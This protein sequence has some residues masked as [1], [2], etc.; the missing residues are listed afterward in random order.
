MQGIAIAC[1]GQAEGSVRVAIFAATPGTSDEP[2]LR[3]FEQRRSVKIILF[4]SSA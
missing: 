1:F 2:M 4:C 3:C